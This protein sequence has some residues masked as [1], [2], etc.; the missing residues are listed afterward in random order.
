MNQAIPT[1]FSVSFLHPTAGYRN[2]LPKYS[3]QSSA[4][5][6]TYLLVDHVDRIFMPL[7]DAILYTAHFVKTQLPWSVTHKMYMSTLTDQ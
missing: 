5:I 7:K 1:P 4:T 6:R 3:E 2:A